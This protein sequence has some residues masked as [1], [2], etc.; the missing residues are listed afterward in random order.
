M[1]STIVHYTAASLSYRYLQV[2][3]GS[4]PK[5]QTDEFDKAKELTKV[6]LTVYTRLSFTRQLGQIFF[7][8]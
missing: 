8:S 4:Y 6:M 5:H 7:Y 1:E 3:L 2:T